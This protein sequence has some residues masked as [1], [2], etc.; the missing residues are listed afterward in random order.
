MK[1]IKEVAILVVIVLLFFVL[2]IVT[3]LGVISQDFQAIAKGIPSVLGVVAALALASVLWD[4]P[5]GKVAIIVICIIVLALGSFSPARAAEEGEPEQ[6]RLKLSGS[7]EPPARELV[8]NSQ[9]FIS[10]GVDAEGSNLRYQWQYFPEGGKSW[11]NWSGRTAGVLYEM[12][13]DRMDGWMIRCKVTGTGTDEVTGTVNLTVRPVLLYSSVTYP[14][15][16][17]STTSMSL[18]AE[19]NGT[20]GDIYTI[21]LKFSRSDL[22]YQWCWGNKYDGTEWT[23][24]PGETKPTIRVTLDSALNGKY[25]NCLIKD[26]KGNV[27]SL[28]SFCRFNYLT[29]RMNAARRE[30]TTEKTIYALTSG[31][32]EYVSIPADY[33]TKIDAAGRTC[34]VVSGETAKAENGCIVP[35]LIKTHY[36][37][38]D[39]VYEEPRFGDTVFLLDG[40]ETLRVH[41]VNYAQTYAENVIDSYLAKNIT[42][43]MTEREKAELC[44]KFVCSYDYSGSATNYVGLVLTGGG[45]C[46]AS[47]NTLLYMFRKLGIQAQSHDSRNVMGG[48]GGHRNVSAKLDGKYCIVEAGFGGTAPRRYSIDEYQSMFAC[49]SLGDGKSVAVLALMNP[50]KI[51]DITVPAEIDGKTVTVLNYGALRSHSEVTS[52]TLPDTLQVMGEYALSGCSMRTIT[53]PAAVTSISQS[54]FYNCDM[55]ER[56]EVAAGGTGEYISRDGILYGNGGKELIWCPT[57]RTGDAEVPEGTEQID[58]G[59]FNSVYLDNLKLPATLK[60]VGEKAFYIARIQKVIFSDGLETIPDQCLK[61]STVGIVS[62]PQ[63]VKTIG[64]EAFSGSSLRAVTLPEGLETIGESAF[65][66]TSIKQIRIPGSVRTIGDKAFTLY[67]GENNK[68]LILFS[69]EYENMTL[70]QDVFSGAVLGVYEG[71][72]IHEYA[73]QNGIPFI[74]LDRN[75]RVPLQQAWFNTEVNDYQYT[76]E[77]IHPLVR[78]KTLE[79]PFSLE[80]G[81]DYEFEWGE[82]TDPGTGTIRIKGLGLFCG[83]LD[84]EFRIVGGPKTEPEQPVPRPEAEPSDQPEPVEP[85]SG[86]ESDQSPVDQSESG[87]DPDKQ[88]ETAEQAEP[89][90]QPEPDKQSETIEQTESSDQPE[91]DKQSETIEQTE[92]SDQPE[93]AGKSETAEQAE[94]SEQPAPGRQSETGEQPKTDKQSESQPDPAKADPEPADK[95]EAFVTRCYSLILGREPDVEGLKGW[96]DALKSGAATAAQIIDGFVRSPEYVGR[97]PGYGESVDILYRTMLGRAADAEGKAGW[98]DALN[99]GYS[100]Q[101]IINGFCGSA[102]FTAICSRYGITA[103]NVS[104]NP[105]NPQPAA[106]TPRGKIE[107]FVRRCYSLILS[108]EADQGGLQGW[109]DALEQRTA[110][111]AQIIDGFVRSPEYA[112]RNL[113]A[114]ERISC[115]R[116]CWAGRRTKA[117]RPAGSTRWARDIPCSTLSTAS[118][119]RRSSR[120]SAITTASWPAAWR[121][122]V[123]W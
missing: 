33:P 91:P 11:I 50:D 78:F 84:I 17:S 58:P 36:V 77:A 117:G 120:R 110:A 47:T 4:K 46:W 7:A 123:Q 18:G 112:G 119:D 52:V 56:I 5:I 31:G 28:R 14:N 62:L 51:S 100:L 106:D 88:P 64:K 95:V 67:R 55:L 57:A 48:L 69:A 122:A 103:G 3:K 35:A 90:E 6:I 73:K 104:V 63:S 116:P 20:D 8:L 25:L 82:N 107:A 13:E 86:P 32:R 59:A 99:K 87:P 1:Y 27:I 66:S 92:S 9:E 81:K 22:S 72:Q 109:S 65:T 115:I 75:G 43:G 108:R 29:L 12:A 2:G 21:S 111:A 60:D 37:N 54:C 94:P 71:S 80:E 85:Q 74:L 68:T 23:N 70:G 114:G 113:G 83:S 15:G 76:G 97:N 30:T 40:K 96:S 19:L 101:H 93:P 49:Y 121:S 98:V 24:L 41:V 61:G 45:D 44:C 102:E 10:L 26:K 16:G 38:S 105:V 53:I 79:T 42:A 34:T 118:A 89:S 39:T